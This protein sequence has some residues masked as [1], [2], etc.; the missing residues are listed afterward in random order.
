MVLVLLSD[1]IGL[2]DP[3]EYYLRLPIS[4]KQETH[5]CLNDFCIFMVQ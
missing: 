4:T 5:N 2:V 1:L 3:A